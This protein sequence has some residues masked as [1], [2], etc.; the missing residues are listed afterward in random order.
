MFLFSDQGL[1]GKIVGNVDFTGFFFFFRKNLSA[2]VLKISKT[3]ANKIKQNV[4][5]QEYSE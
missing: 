3:N 2:Q 5:I 1:S 4:S